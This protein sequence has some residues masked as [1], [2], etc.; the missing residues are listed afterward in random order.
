[1]FAE[2]EQQWGATITAQLVLAEATPAPD[3]QALRAHCREALA[4]YKIPGR[5]QWV[6]RLTYTASGKKIRN[7]ERLRST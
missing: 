7:A 5:F 2:G 6:Q 4:S 1:M 3:E